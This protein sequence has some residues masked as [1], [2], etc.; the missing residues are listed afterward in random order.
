MNMKHIT[1][2]LIIVL[3]IMTLPLVSAD[4]AT[5]KVE[6][7]KYEPIPAQ[8]GQYV[9]AYLEVENTGNE[10]A[11]NAAIE[12]QNQ[13]PFTA[14][15]KAESHKSFGIIK[16]QQSIVETI[17]LRVASDALVGTNELKL[18]YTADETTSN[19]QETNLNIEVKSNDASLTITEIATEP[20]EFSPGGEGTVTIT[21]KNNEDLVLRNIGL[22]LGLITIQGTTVTDLPFI[23][24]G[25]ATEKK[26]SK[27]NPGEFADVSFKVKAY[28]SA[29]PGYYKLPITLTFYDDQGTETENQDYIGVIIQAQPE[30][31]I[32]LDDTQLT[33]EQLTGDIT[34]KFVNKGVSDL[35]FLDIKVKEGDNYK[36][37][38]KTSEYIGDLDSDDYRSETFTIEAQGE[39]AELNVEVSYKDENN[40]AYSYTKT[41]PLSYNNIPNNGKGQSSTITIIIVLVVLAG[42]I[43]FWRRSKRRK[44]RRH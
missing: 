9:T 25:S 4:S 1:L 42:I 16:S 26:I 3:S 27:L 22:Q 32:Y 37:L 23:P 5:L 15:S 11:K 6:L 28:P 30:L 29:T 43:Y 10:D 19:W 18:R 44:K 31:K 21:V 34:L 17:R 33:A 38:S 14:I 39:N 36:V 20:E 2:A 41:V 7:L 12:I 40:K 13:F 8:P 35:K 24:T